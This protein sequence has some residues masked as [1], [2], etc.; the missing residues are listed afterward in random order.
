M[1]DIPLSP[2]SFFEE[3][4]PKE[5]ASVG[6]ALKGRTSP[7]AVA[8]ELTGGDSWSLRLSDGKIGVTRGVAA[9][10]IVRI[11][12]PAD[13][14]APVIVAGAERLAANS[15]F[16]RGLVAV[17]VL[18]LDAERARMLRETKGS[19]LLRLSSPE[20]ERKLTLTL[21]GVAPKLEAPDAEIACAL[22]DLWAIQSGTKNPFELL[23]DGKLRLSG[24][25]QLA[26]A[27]GAALGTT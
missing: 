15:G 22:E 25:V 23:M 18:T 9:D 11:T 12:L 21:G 3:Y 26:M 14:F 13:D 16:D 19:L 17:R 7:G 24:N 10:S 6:D 5:L 2:A 27:L 4:A 1:S 8:F 20:A